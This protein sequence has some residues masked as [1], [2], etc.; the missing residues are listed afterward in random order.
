MHPETS[1]RAGAVR[2]QKRFQLETLST[3]TNTVSEAVS[4]DVRGV[5]KT[6]QFGTASSIIEASK[7]ETRNAR[8]CPN[9]ARLSGRRCL[10][11]HRLNAASQ[12]MLMPKRA[13]TPPTGPQLPLSGI[14]ATRRNFRG[15]QRRNEVWPHFPSEVR[16]Q[17]RS[18]GLMQGS[19]VFGELPRGTDMHVAPQK[20]LEQE[21]VS[22]SSRL[23]HLTLFDWLLSVSSLGPV[24]GKRWNLRAGG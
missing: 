24:V 9:H 20:A 17:A 10:G 22:S 23:G 11:T 8:C 1:L 4:T 6:D 18:S 14:N 2:P 13:E 7:I 21:R 16:I 3:R 19:C 5:Q 15:S 12:K